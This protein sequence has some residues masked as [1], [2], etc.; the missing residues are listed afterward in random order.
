MT[1]SGLFA[2]L[3]RGHGGFDVMPDGKSLLLVTPTGEPQQTMVV[4][5][6]ADELRAANDD[7]RAQVS[8]R[9]AGA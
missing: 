5:N 7:G 2:V 4:L 9:A 3:N 8:G 1:E 6:W